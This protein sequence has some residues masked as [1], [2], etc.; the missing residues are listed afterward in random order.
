MEHNCAGGPG[1]E[2]KAIISNWIRL[3]EAVAAC[4]QGLHAVV[5]NIPF[6]PAVGSAVG[7]WTCQSSGDEA[8]FGGQLCMISSHFVP[9]AP[10]GLLSDMD[11]W[12]LRSSLSFVV[13]VFLFMQ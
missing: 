6:C 4:I 12:I 3:A 1:A 10:F 13:A 5:S 9:F 2:G 11:P 8:R 7:L